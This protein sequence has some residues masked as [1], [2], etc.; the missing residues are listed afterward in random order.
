M[1]VLFIGG[2]WDG[3][4]HEIEDGIRMWFVP[5]AVE[6]DAI[7]AWRDRRAGD[8]IFDAIFGVEFNHHAYR[9]YPIYIH[10]LE[11]HVGY[12]GDSFDIDHIVP[13]FLLSDKAKELFGI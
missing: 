12:A 1:K 3:E 5:K 6:W 7:T 9:I 13:R 4:L 10:G 8:A 2:P 11:G